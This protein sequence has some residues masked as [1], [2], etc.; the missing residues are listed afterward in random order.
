MLTWNSKRIMCVQSV[1][2]E[3]FG[4]VH[5]LL[6]QLIKIY[7]TL[8]ENNVSSSHNTFYR[9]CMLHLSFWADIQNYFL[10]YL[11]T[12][13][14]PHTFTLFKIQLDLTFLSG[15]WFKSWHEFLT[16]VRTEAR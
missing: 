16:L 12:L 2:K 13:F 11:L 7:M 10:I 14:F 15:N 9:Y 5:I 6:E 4:G 3:K 8:N 1:K